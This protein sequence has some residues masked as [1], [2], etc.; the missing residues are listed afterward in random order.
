MDDDDSTGKHKD[1]DV[2][3]KYK[4]LAAFFVIGLCIG[5]VIAER[6]Y[7][8]NSKG[9][10]RRRSLTVA[11]SGSMAATA[12]IKSSSAAGA[13]FSKPARNDL[14]TLLRKVNDHRAHHVAMRPLTRMRERAREVWSL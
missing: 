9:S 8:S 2:K 6:L 4:G 14:E 3:L 5:V 10:P 11:T 12:A 7:V 13:D 1:R